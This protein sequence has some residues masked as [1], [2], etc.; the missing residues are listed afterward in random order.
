MQ[1]GWNGFLETAEDGD[2]KLHF[3]DGQ[4]GDFTVTL[5]GVSVAQIDASDY[6]F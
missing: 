3:F 4:G 5:D 1:M 2:A 6:I